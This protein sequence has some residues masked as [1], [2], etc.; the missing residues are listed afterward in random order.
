MNGMIAWIR[1]LVV[2][3]NGP[4]ALK[5]ALEAA[6]IIVACVTVGALGGGFWA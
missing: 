6:R 1:R 2:S 5:L 4:T 3:G